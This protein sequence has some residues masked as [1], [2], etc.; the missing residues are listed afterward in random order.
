MIFFVQTKYVKYEQILYF[1]CHKR[2]AALG[3]MKMQLVKK[4]K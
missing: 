3:F 2:I 4:S 1:Y